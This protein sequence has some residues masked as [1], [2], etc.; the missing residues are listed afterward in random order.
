MKNIQV[1][2]TIYSLPLQNEAPQWGEQLSS[3]IEA[4]ANQLNGIAGPYDSTNKLFEFENNI[5][6]PT[7]IVGAVVDPVVVN[8]AIVTYSVR[9]MTSS[10][11]ASEVGQLTVT[12]NASNPAS[13]KF[14]VS[15]FKAG[16]AGIEFNFTD[17]GNLQYT[18]NNLAGT[19]HVGRMR[20]SIKAFEI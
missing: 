8:G 4:I 5:T 6:T 7:D 13:S 1:G 18:T 3:L 20:F 10:V 9:R 17:V 11:T 19:G 14:D 16:S 12:Y 2:N 15:Q